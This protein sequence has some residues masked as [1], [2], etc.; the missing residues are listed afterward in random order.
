M[1]S[2]FHSLLIGAVLIGTTFSSL[3]AQQEGKPKTLFSSGK[4]INTE[5][6]GFFVAPKVGFTQ[7]DG[8]NAVL[9]N[10]RAGMSL[11][12]T[13]AF[14]AF[15]NTSLN[16][17]NPQSVILPPI[18][19]NVY[20]DY[21]NVGGF[22]E[23]TAYSNKLVHLSFPLYLGYGEVQ[24]DNENGDAGLGEAQFFQVEPSALLELNV[25]K[26]VRFNAGLGYRLVSEVNYLGIT[27]SELSGFTGYIGLKFGLF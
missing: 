21:W 1:T 18:V 19:N 13:F 2:I 4:G 26:N 12:P 15:F 6:L 24:M 27:A 14:G 10:L 3:N 16:R 9:F 17:I 7:I 25:H 11:H 22:A 20:L 5:N 8:D 23:F